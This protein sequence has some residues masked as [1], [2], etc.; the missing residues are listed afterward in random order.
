VELPV[1][2]NLLQHFTSCS[3][4]DAQNVLTLKESFPF[5]QVLH[6]LSAR[7]SKDHGLR[8]FKKE[9]QLAA[10]YAAD[11]GVLK[12]I[13]E[14]DF[15]SELHEVMKTVPADSGAS[16]GVRPGTG[17]IAAELLEDMERLNRLRENFELLFADASV[18]SF[19]TPQGASGQKTAANPDVTEE[20]LS[21]SLSEPVRESLKSRKERIIELAKSVTAVEPEAVPE[22]GPKGRKKRKDSVEII[23]DQIVTT[24][25]EIEPENEKL[26]QQIEIIDEFIKVQPSISGIKDK[27]A[28]ADDLSTIKTG[29]FTESIISETLVEILLKQG[30]KDKA[31]EVLKKL[32]WKFPQKKAYFATQ[33]EELRK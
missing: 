17:D 22:A 1:F 30:K 21:S 8:D 28:A 31:V 33:I 7:V 15:A 26:K 18:T 10:V 23:I 11:R 25:Q 32:I 5:S 3:E 9:L 16:V 27:Q 2:I 24:K 19:Q 13:M 20:T 14:A 4:L 29:E 6:T 12:D